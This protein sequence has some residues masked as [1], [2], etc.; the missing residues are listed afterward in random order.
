LLRIG[1]TTHRLQHGEDE[2]HDT[3]RL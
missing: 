1:S 3:N 2:L